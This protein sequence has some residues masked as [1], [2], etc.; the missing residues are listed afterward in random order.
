VSA[1]RR[2][3]NSG[4]PVWNAAGDPPCNQ[5]D[6]VLAGAHAAVTFS[7]QADRLRAAASDGR[8]CLMTANTV[9]V[10]G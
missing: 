10:I 5:A 3:S 9:A 7:D 1:A 8:Q 4:A 2:S 6:N